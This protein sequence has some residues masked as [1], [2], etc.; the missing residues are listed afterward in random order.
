MRISEQLKPLRRTQCK[1]HHDVSGRKFASGNIWLGGEDRFNLAKH[2]VR[3]VTHRADDFLMSIRI[4]SVDGQPNS[5]VDGVSGCAFCEM[6][7][8]EICRPILLSDQRFELPISIQT[9]Y[10]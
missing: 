9:Q 8:V 4:V 2:G 5:H 10:V 6:Q 3:A 1:A 7:P